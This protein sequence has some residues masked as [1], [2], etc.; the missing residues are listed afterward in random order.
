MNE[1]ELANTYFTS[2]CVTGPTIEGVIIAPCVN[3]EYK[4]DSKTDQF[5]DWK[6][7]ENEE[8]MK[9]NEKKKLLDETKKHILMERMENKIKYKK[10]IIEKFMECYYH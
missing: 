6:I 4:V 1:F 9:I 7:M 2:A 5:Y 3:D 8:Y 10:N